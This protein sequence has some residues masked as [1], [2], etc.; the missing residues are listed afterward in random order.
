MLQG[1]LRQITLKYF[2]NVL[3]VSIKSYSVPAYSEFL[4]RLMPCYN[5]YCESIEDIAD[6]KRGVCALF[7]KPETRTV[8]I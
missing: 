7:D 1:R 3:G 4:N 5:I 6:H 2:V 8:V